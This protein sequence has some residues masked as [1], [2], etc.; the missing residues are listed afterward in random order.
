MRP[1]MCHMIPNMRLTNEKSKLDQHL[2]Q[3]VASLTQFPNLIEYRPSSFNHNESIVGMT[4]LE[5]V[6]Y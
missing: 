6:T 1:C 5:P 3:Q 2:L 4:G